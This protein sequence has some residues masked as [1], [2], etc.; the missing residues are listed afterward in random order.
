MKFALTLWLA[1]TLKSY[2]LEMGSTAPDFVLQGSPVEVQLHAQNG[3][4]VVLE[5]Y[6]DGCP[7]VR[8]HYD[9][10]NMQMLQKKY[11]GK[12]SWLTINSSAPGKQGYLADK[13]AA[14]QRFTK[15]QM[16]SMSLLMDSKGKVGQQ[17]QAKT[18]PHMYIIDPMGRVVYQGAIDSI[19]SA[20]ASDIPRAKNYVS[21]ALDEALNGKPI[22][23]SKTQAYGCS[24]KY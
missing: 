4:Y 1:F 6:N 21:M 19:S 9:S 20:D 13:K 16:K 22:S 17:F 14:A 23:I 24:V 2:A 18:T 12:V 8:K 3:K 5:W 7:F 11:A 15:E 10:K